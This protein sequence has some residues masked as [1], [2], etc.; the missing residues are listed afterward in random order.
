M[1]LWLNEVRASPQLIQHPPEVPN[2]TDQMIPKVIYCSETLPVH[3][4]S[5]RLQRETLNLMN[6][7]P[8]CDFTL[9]VTDSCIKYLKIQSIPCPRTAAS[10][11]YLQPNSRHV[12][13]ARGKKFQLH[14]TGV[15]WTVSLSMPYHMVPGPLG[16][17]SQHF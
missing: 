7:F 1:E 2:T 4:I 5:V 11:K 13:M 16:P 9:L 17:A 8:F 15:G 14:G 6:D 12:R 10:L 3:I